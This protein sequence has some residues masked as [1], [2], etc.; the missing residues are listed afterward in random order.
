MPTAIA[1]VAGRVMS[2]VLIAS[3]NP[4]PSAPSRCSTGTSQ[5]VKWSATVGEA[6]MPIF[7]SFL[8][9]AK[10]GIPFSTRKAVTPLARFFGSTVAKTVITSAWS[11]FVHHCLE[12][13]RT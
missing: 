1:P 9:T 8:P 3:V 6:R 7:F 5:S 12:P 10:P 4:S 11:P 2:S 13:F